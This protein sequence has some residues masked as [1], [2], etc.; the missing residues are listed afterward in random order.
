M[1]GGAMV[2][3]AAVVIVVLLVFVLPKGDEQ[4]QTTPTARASAASAPPSSSN[5]LGIVTPLYVIPT[6]LIPKART[7]AKAWHKDAAL[8]S[9]E[10]GPVVNGHLNL[11]EGATVRF[12]FGRPAG[13]RLGPGTKVAAQERL[14][15]IADADGIQSK[16]EPGTAAVAAAEP[17]CPFPDVWKKVTAA[18]IPADSNPTF[19]FARDTK[20]ERELWTVTAQTGEGDAGETITRLVDGF[21]CTIILR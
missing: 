10:A 6:E 17:S 20:R 13:A 7:K 16:K 18:G 9:I 14:V 19:R 5:A 8:V 4:G 12:E 3:L 15:L 1:I 11:E 21:K 2:G